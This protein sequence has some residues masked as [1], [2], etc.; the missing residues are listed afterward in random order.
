MGKHNSKQ[1]DDEAFI[2]ML[3]DKALMV[4]VSGSSAAPYRDY[5][6]RHW[7]ELEP[8]MRGCAMGGILLAGEYHISFD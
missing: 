2:D 7:N 4:Y 1:Q 8:I 5:I 3:V 6:K